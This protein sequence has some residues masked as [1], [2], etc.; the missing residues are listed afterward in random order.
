M[1]NLS[2]L[3]TADAPTGFAGFVAKYGGLIMIVLMCVLLY[4]IMIRPQRKQEKETQQMRN[5][6]AIGDEIITIGGIVG[7]II[8]LSGEDT[9]TI[10]SSRDR[11]RIQILRSAISK[12]QVP[13]NPAPEAKEK[14][15][16]EKK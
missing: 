12:V 13:A 10:V 14:E 15:P 1:H 9:V 4:F 5:N 2:I 7:I 8:S 16:A 11:T 6:L 3:L